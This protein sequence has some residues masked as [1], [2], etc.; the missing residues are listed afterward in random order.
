VLAPTATGRRVAARWLDEPVRHLRDVR[1]ELLVKLALRERGGMDNQALLR[2]QQALFDPVVDALTSSRRDDDLV[3]VWRRE[4]A[5]AVRRFLDEALAA[6]A[7][8]ATA[9][10]EIH[11]SARNQLRSTVTEVHHGEVMSTIK[12]V[13]GDGQPLTAAI[14]KEAARDLDLAP[15]DQVVVLIKSTE[16]IVAKPAV[17]P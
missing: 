8:S 12:A 10:P 6:R 9:K 1:T 7:A 15:G 16:V 2:A 14:T 5:R 3:D 11:L 4:S 13:L 17:T